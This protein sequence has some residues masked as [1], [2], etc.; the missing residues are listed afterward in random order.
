MEISKEFDA[1]FFVLFKF[2]NSRVDKGYYQNLGPWFLIDQSGHVT[3]MGLALGQ[4]EDFGWRHGHLKI[5][6]LLGH[7]KYMGLI[8]FY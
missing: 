1:F 4:L 7:L 5:M 6:G 8:L 2:I 3:N